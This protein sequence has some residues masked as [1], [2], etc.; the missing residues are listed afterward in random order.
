MRT[1]FLKIAYQFMEK[2][3]PRLMKCSVCGKEFLNIRQKKYCSNMC[4]QALR[5]EYKKKWLSK[6]LF[7]KKCVFCGSDF[8][9]HTK[10]KKFCSK[11]CRNNVKVKK[12]YKQCV[13]CKN[14]FLGLSHRKYCSNGCR[15]QALTGVR[16][17]KQSIP[18]A[19]CGITMELSD[20]QLFKWGKRYCS[21]RCAAKGRRVVIG[22]THTCDDCKRTLPVTTEFFR[23]QGRG[24][25]WLSRCN[26]CWHIRNYFRVMGIDYKKLPSKI[27]EA[28][29]ILLF[30][31]HELKQNKL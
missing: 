6:Q 26:Q 3:K 29:R 10:N 12:Q 27:K 4:K 14:E 18:C 2:L 23:K 11:S 7:N 25:T 30:I 1:Q 24:V 17:K 28:K 20:N 19:Y 13:T 21:N 9:S 8:Q 15:H 31:K 5:A 22:V 16:V